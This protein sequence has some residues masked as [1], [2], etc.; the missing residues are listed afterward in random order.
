[1]A[2]QGFEALMAGEKKV[3]AAALVVKAQEAL[4][5]VVPDTVEALGDRAMAKPRNRL[6]N[7]PTVRPSTTRCGPRPDAG[8]NS[9][10]TERRAQ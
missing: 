3:V 8:G 4:S 1:V 6:P 7:R 10:R 9:P 2:R 5:K